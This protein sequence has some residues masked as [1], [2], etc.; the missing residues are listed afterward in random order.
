VGAKDEGDGEYMQGEPRSRFG[1]TWLTQHFWQGREH[2]QQSP[3]SPSRKEHIQ[4]PSEEISKYL[5]DLRSSKRSGA[6]ILTIKR[7]Q[8]G[9][10][11][12][13]S[14]SEVEISSVLNTIL[15]ETSTASG[16][17]DSTFDPSIIPRRGTKNY[18][19]QGD[20]AIRTCV[21]TE[22]IDDVAVSLKHLRLNRPEHNERRGRRGRK[23][24]VSRE[25]QMIREL[26][27]ENIRLKVLVRL[28]DLPF[29]F[30]EMRKLTDTP[31]GHVS[32]GIQGCIRH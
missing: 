18:K 7:D 8:E 2:G 31:L 23:P 11:E 30:T 9:S 16:S 15:D 1:Q 22:S 21:D 12:I 26:E 5:T 24:R 19:Q 14:D 27:D 6:P 3:S 17:E 25:V 29:E 13:H 4:A 10:T 20:R 28:G 32:T